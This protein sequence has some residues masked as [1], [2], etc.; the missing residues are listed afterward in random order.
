M[1]KLFTIAILTGCLSLASAQTTP[2][3]GTKSMEG[4]IINIDK[5]K[6]TVVIQVNYAFS[7]DAAAEIQ[8]AGKKITLGELKPGTKV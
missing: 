6:N 4:A 1:K 5:E 3:A 2:K 7:V 8:S